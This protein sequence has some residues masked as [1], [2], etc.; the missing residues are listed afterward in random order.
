MLIR[1]R[2]VAREVRIG[3]KR[4]TYKIM[5]SKP[6]EMRYSNQVGVSGNVIF[7]TDFREIDPEGVKLK[8]FHE[9]DDDKGRGVPVLN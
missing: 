1:T 5:A 2:W 7:E 9:H 4:N 8:R 6:Q 3:E